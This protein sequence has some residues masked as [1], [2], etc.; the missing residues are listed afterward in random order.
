MAEVPVLTAISESPENNVFVEQS[1]RPVVHFVELVR[2]C[3]VVKVVYRCIAP[4]RRW[5]GLFVDES[6]Y[7]SGLMK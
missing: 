5:S 2:V 1:G 4:V 6:M 3:E 7:W